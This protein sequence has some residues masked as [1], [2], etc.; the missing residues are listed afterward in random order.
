MIMQAT[1]IRLERFGGG[2]ELASGIVRAGDT[3]VVVD[4]I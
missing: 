3:L 2:E 1:T 4:F